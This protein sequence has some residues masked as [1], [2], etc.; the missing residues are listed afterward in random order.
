[1]IHLLI[2]ALGGAIG[3]SLRYLS[4]LAILRIAGP[5][6]PYGTLFVNVVGSFIMGLI[7][8]WLA[9]RT[10]GS[11]AELRLFL[12]TGLLGGF[13]TFSAFSLDFAN[14]WQRGDTTA[15]F[16]YVLASVFISVLAIFAGLWLA[17][18][19]L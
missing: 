5:A 17:R 1:M 3:A 11:S 16:T 2:V 18:T 10:G 4:G 12:A 14:M 6:F 15:A 9:K 8:A 7:I 19:V 13:T